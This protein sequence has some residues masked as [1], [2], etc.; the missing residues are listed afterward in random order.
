MYVLDD[1][2][3]ISALALGCRCSVG[4]SIHPMQYLMPKLGVPLP[5]NVTVCRN[6]TVV[7]C[8]TT[9]KAFWASL[10]TYMEDIK[11]RLTKVNWQSGHW[12]NSFHQALQT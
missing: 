3:L 11:E 10:S 8:L 7:I 9:C 2:I 6:K 5:R 4:Y 1:S 12:S